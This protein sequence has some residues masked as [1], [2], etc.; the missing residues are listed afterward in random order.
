MSELLNEIILLKM[1]DSKG[2]LSSPKL[3]DSWLKNEKDIYNFILSEREKGKTASQAIYD[4]LNNIASNPKCESCE[5]KVEF[6]SFFSGYR[7]TCGG[8]SCMRRA[9]GKNPHIPTQIEREMLSRRMKE[10]NPMFNEEIKNKAHATQI[11]KYGS[12]GYHTIDA[13]E[14]A[15]DSRFD[16]FGTFSPKSKL[17][18][19]KPYKMPDDSIVYIQ[20]YEY[21]ALDILISQKEDVVL[22]GKKH[23]F[24]YS[25]K[26]RHKTYYPDIFIPNKNLYIEVKSQYTF[27]VQKKQNL[28]KREAVL[29][30]GFNFEFWIFDQ[31]K[32]L[33]IL[34]S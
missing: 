7:K 26:E 3:R 29:S 15:L 30:A 22:C 18:K 2:R 13:K 24:R 21:M 8:D 31:N 16:K 34:N 6:H 17:F 19:P 4:K 9:Y 11:K 14:K 33:T 28:A 10:K 27:E 23:K 32:N 1:F 12:L 5:E 20:G 25:F